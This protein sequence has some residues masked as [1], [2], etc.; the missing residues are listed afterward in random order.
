M[1]KTILRQQIYDVLLVDL[2]ETCSDEVL[3]GGVAGDTIEDAF[4]CSG[5]DTLVILICD[6]TYHCMSL[7]STRL[8]IGK[9]GSIV[10]FKDTLNNRERSLIKDVLLKST[11]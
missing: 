1:L 4:E 11:L 8:P 3:L 5:D 10:A 7:S 2:Q 9:D 6:D